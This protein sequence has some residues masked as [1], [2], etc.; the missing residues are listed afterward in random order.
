[1]SIQV[2]IVED[3]A[4]VREHLA[5]LLAQDPGLSCCT[6]CGSGEEALRQL[7]NSKA[8]VVLMDVHLPGI[9]GIDCVASLS[10]LLPDAHFVMLTVSDDSDNVFRA[11]EMG[12]GGYLLKRSPPSEILKAIREVH[13]GGAPM[14]GYIA[15]KVVQS[16]QR[17]GPSP[18]E[19]ENLSPR[20]EEIL[21]HVARG[22]INK[23]IA[24]ALGIGLET[25]RTHL[26]SIYEKLHVR[27]RTEA[28]VKGL[29]C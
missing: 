9:S 25:V 8:E 29:R 24:E 16:F 6:T 4:S 21:R 20:E 23:E 26:K 2:A 12:A 22:Y 10:Q 5:A 19:A 27:S 1:M 13:G 3:D 18:R 14:S 17:R 7:P 15:R 28:V 11:L